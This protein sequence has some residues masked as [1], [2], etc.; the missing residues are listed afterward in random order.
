VGTLVWSDFS[1]FSGN[2]T[3]NCI[4]AGSWAGESFL[5][6]WRLSYSGGREHFFHSPRAV[7]IFVRILKVGGIPAFLLAALDVCFM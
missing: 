3:L 6:L 5:L 4:G 1:A 2:R 7:G